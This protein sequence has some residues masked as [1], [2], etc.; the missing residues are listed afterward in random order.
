ME[1]GFDIE[2]YI[3]ENASFLDSV[4]NVIELAMTLETQSLDLYLRFSEKSK[5]PET[6]DVLLKIAEEEKSHLKSLGN[7]L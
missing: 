1:G 3:K 2:K 7:L 4:Q 6:K 5:H